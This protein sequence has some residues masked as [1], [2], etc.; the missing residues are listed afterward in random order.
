MARRCISLPGESAGAAADRLVAEGVLAEGDADAVHDFAEFL[1]DCAATRTR[2]GG[3]VPTAV[4]WKHRKY[5]GLS[6]VEVLDVAA[7]RG[8]PNPSEETD[9][10]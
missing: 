9:H 4:L 7:R 2:H 3:P 10:A 5:L 1:R 6:D 8:E